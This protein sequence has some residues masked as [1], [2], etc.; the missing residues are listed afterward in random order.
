MQPRTQ[1]ILQALI[2]EEVDDQS[3]LVLQWKKNPTCRRLHSF[4]PW[5]C[6]ESGVLT[7]L[8]E[9]FQQWLP[10]SVREDLP[11]H[12]PPQVR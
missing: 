5:H 2:K 11:P 1:A 4:P 7:V 3:K 10:E 12:W 9:E 8:M 6:N